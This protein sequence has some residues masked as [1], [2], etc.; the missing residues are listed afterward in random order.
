MDA[1]A[2]P[3]AA[4]ARGPRIGI[5]KARERPWRFWVPD[6]AALWGTALEP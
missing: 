1:P 5:S 6:P 3:E 2:V 4:V